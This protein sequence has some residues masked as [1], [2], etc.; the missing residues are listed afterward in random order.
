MCQPRA[1]FFASILTFSCKNSRVGRIVPIHTARWWRLCPLLSSSAGPRLDR[2]LIHVTECIL[3]APPSPR[4]EVAVCP[5]LFL[6]HAF[7]HGSAS[8]ETAWLK[9]RAG[10]ARMCQ[11]NRGSAEREPRVKSQE[12]L[13]EP[14]WGQIIGDGSFLCYLQMTAPHIRVPPQLVAVLQLARIY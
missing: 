3:A 9:D 7:P 10:L 8:Y 1:G 12:S 6:K 4:I 14:S 13:R 2:W 11:G 5:G